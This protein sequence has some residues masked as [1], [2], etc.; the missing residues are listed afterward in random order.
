MLGS[1]FFFFLTYKISRL[2]VEENGAFV[3]QAT[4]QFHAFNGGIQMLL[5]WEVP[6]SQ[7]EIPYING[8]PPTRMTAQ[9][10]P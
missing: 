1:K 10:C 5:L 3:M 7:T 9:Q 4:F 6:H 8:V 2:F